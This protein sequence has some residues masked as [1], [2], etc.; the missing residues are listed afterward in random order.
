MSRHATFFCQFHGV[1]R[2]HNLMEAATASFMDIKS[3]ATTDGDAHPNQNSFKD[4]K[5]A[6]EA[7]AEPHHSRMHLSRDLT[8]EEKHR[9]AETRYDVYTCTIR[10]RNAPVFNMAGVFLWFLPTV[11]SLANSCHVSR[12][13]SICVI[14]PFR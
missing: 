1:Y 10:F 5:T 7:P 13:A 3:D 4:A 8:E 6:F 12:A 9:V 11:T 14:F 2:Q